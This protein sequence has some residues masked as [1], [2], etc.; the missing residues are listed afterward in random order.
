[1]RKEVPILF[2]TS[3]V[4]AILEGR[5]TQTRRICKDNGDTLVGYEYVTDCP[6]YPDTWAG[7]QSGNYTGWIARFNN[8]PLAM[9]RKCPFGG[10]DDLIWVREE[11]YR[12]GY[13]VKNGLTKKG[14]QKWKF[15]HI[16][17]GV[18]FSDNPPKDIN[19]PIRKSRDK[20][21]P[22]AAT[23]YKRLARFMPK[24]AARIWLE[25]TEV[26]VERLQ[27]ITEEDA[28]AEGIEHGDVLGMKSWKDYAGSS[29]RGFF[30]DG[31]NYSYP[32]GKNPQPA[33]VA[34]YCTLWFDINGKENWDVNPWVWVI[35]F[36]V[37]STT[38]LPSFKKLNDIGAV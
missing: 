32:N 17:G 37:L 26:R 15:T 18:M 24:F 10:V 12:F 38:G 35:S 3:M 8:I 25:I 30:L 6:T 7:K 33:A 9:P 29:R 4:Q 27:E 31:G 11:H 21:A 1:M 14:N 34:S 28:I 5:K 13:W 16:S 20:E 22:E 2:S 19:H 23:W 36:K